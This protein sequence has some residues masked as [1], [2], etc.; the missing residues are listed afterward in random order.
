M[1]PQEA[2]PQGPNEAGPALREPT[3]RPQEQGLCG[4]GGIAARCQG[5]RSSGA[6]GFKDVLSLRPLLLGLLLLAALPGHCQADSGKHLAA[7]RPRPDL[8][9]LNRMVVGGGLLAAPLGFSLSLALVTAGELS[10]IS[11]RESIVGG[12]ERGNFLSFF[13]PRRVAKCFWWSHKH[14]SFS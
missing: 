8:K 9:Q 4:A 3:D 6:R 14:S 2:N 10:E 7:L 11:L 5:V 13:F 1:A 12:E